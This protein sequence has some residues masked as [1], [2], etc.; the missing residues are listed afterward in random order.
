SARSKHF[1][2]EARQARQF[3]VIPGP[4]RQGQRR[5]AVRSDL[6]QAQL[7][8]LRMET[9]NSDPSGQVS[10][11]ATLEDEQAF[12]VQVNA[13]RRAEELA[14]TN[15]DVAQRDAFVEMQFAAQQ[16]H[17]RNRFPQAEQQIVESGGQP[18]GRLYVACLEDQIRILDITILPEFRGRGIGTR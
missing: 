16:A 13:R 4:D 6:Q 12:L 2:S 1:R 5:R 15:W 8:R 7:Q 14:M 11:R 18:V 3:L 17:Y 10:L 9:N